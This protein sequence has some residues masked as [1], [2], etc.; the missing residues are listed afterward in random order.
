[1]TSFAYVWPVQVIIDVLKPVLVLFHDT[2]GVG[3]GMSIVLLTVCVRALLLPLTVKQ[4]TS[5]QAMV[6]VAP[7]V[8]EIQQKYKDDKPRQSQEVMKFYAKHKISPLASCL[9]L[10]AQLPFFLGLYYLLKSDLRFEICGVGHLACGQVADPSGAERFLFI[11]DLTANATGGVL[12]VLM[13][14]YIGSQLL[15]SWLTP[16]TADANQKLLMYALPIVFSIFILVYA[17]PAGLL[18]YWITSNLWTV[19]QG[20]IVRRTLGSISAPK[21]RPAPASAVSGGL[22]EALTTAASSGAATEKPAPVT[23]TSLPS[24][25]VRRPPGTKK[26]R[27][28][29]RR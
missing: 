13:V 19:G 15:S 25:P 21:M 3:W 17:F 10:A 14:L 11:P 26:K 1:M 5:L 2:V 6:G 7:Q 18:V 4:F 23:A 20:C 12:A 22:V 28:G 16:S 29:K 27:S 24:R 9:P 8:K